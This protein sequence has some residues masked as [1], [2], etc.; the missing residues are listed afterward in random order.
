M[1]LTKIALIVIQLLV[2]LN[3]F[4]G[5]YYGLA[6]AKDIPLSWLDGSPFDSFFIPSLFLFVVIGG[7]M[8]VATLVW[9]RKSSLAPWVSLGMG[10]T[11]MLWIVAQVSIIGYVSWMQPTSFIAGAA[12]VALAGVLLR[13]ARRARCPRPPDGSPREG[14]VTDARRRSPRR[15]ASRARARC[16]SA[17]TQRGFARGQAGRSAAGRLPCPI[18][19]GPAPAPGSAPPPPIVRGRRSW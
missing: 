2:M 5:G 11:L 15:R 19:R 1:K 7:G 16:E 17:A 10:V 3:A 13:A 6:G 9:W 8:L 18:L 14:R 12:I 4:G